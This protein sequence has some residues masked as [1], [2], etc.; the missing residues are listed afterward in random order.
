MMYGKFLS[1]DAYI[2]TDI[3]PN[4]KREEMKTLITS[5]VD[6][7]SEEG[8]KDQIAETA[9]KVHGENSKK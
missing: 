4:S 6:I 5:A 1:N 7:L 2:F 9:Q 3:L 8:Q